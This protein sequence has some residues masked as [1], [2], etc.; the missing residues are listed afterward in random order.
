MQTASSSDCAPFTLLTGQRIDPTAPWPLDT[1]RIGDR[2]DADFLTLAHAQAQHARF[3]LD[4]PLAF[5]WDGQVFDRAS[6]LA[7]NA[8]DDDVCDWVRAARPGDT[9][10]AMGGAVVCI[11]GA[12]ATDLHEFADGAELARAVM[13]FRGLARTAAT[14]REARQHLRLAARAARC[15]RAIAK[16]ALRGDL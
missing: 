13:H 11:S 6:M 2:S 10:P 4:A 15:V 12:I 14:R 8:H 3:E 7:G 9:F 1:R 16:R 5:E